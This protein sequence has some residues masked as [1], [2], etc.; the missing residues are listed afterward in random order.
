MEMVRR[1][2]NLGR[3]ARNKAAIKTRQPLAEAV[4]VATPRSSRPSRRWSIWCSTS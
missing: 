2:I 1:V 3:A 4:V